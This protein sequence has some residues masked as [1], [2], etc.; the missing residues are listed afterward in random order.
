MI[1]LRALQIYIETVL[2]NDIEN[3][4]FNGR[5]DFPPSTNDVERR[6]E[7][8]HLFF[9][10]KTIL[11]EHKSYMCSLCIF[12][13]FFFFFFFFFFFP[14]SMQKRAARK[15]RKTRPLKI[16]LFALQ[17]GDTKKHFDRFAN[18]LQA[19]K[20]ADLG[21]DEKNTI[22]SDERSRRMKFCVIRTRRRHVVFTFIACVCA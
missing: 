3:K 5:E 13:V 12:F 17:G 14:L 7:S 11:T 4:S 10:D 9:S 1:A 20:W 21:D 8:A 22:K 2:Q 16:I 15:M 6:Y 18:T 19:W